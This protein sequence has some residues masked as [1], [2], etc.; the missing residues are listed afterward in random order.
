MYRAYAVIRDSIRT[1]IVVVVF[2]SQGLIFAASCS[3]LRW[4]KSWGGVGVPILSTRCQKKL[5]SSLNNTND[6]IG[7]SARTQQERNHVNITGT[8][9]THR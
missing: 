2:S 6:D 1:G 3:A 8:F 5:G 9:R 4:R 7:T